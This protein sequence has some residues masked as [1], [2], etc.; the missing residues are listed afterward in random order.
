MRYQTILRKTVFT[1]SMLAGFAWPAGLTA[2]TTP[3]AEL[4]AHPDLTLKGM[5]DIGNGLLF[6]LAHKPSDTSHWVSPGE[7][8]EG[9]KL[10][11]YD[12]TNHALEVSR[13]GERFVI[14]LQSGSAPGGTASAAAGGSSESGDHAGKTKQVTKMV[15]SGRGRSGSSTE[16]TMRVPVNPEDGEDGA[17]HRLGSQTGRSGGERSTAEGDDPGDDA[18]GAA[19]SEGKAGA[20]AGPKQHP[21]RRAAIRARMD[22]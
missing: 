13:D 22:S 18:P 21:V 20:D 7:T 17:S 14:W 11:R 6:S 19:S 15:P 1:F 2:E 4:P 5:A 8:V 16:I 9:T 10:I 3:I 12:S